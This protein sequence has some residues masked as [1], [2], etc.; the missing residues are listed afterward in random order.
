MSRI[1]RTFASEADV[2]QF[3][4]D[5]KAALGMPVVGR[6]A[7]TG[8]P[9]P[10]K[11]QTTDWVQVGPATDPEGN[12]IDNLTVTVVRTDHA[13]WRDGLVRA[14]LLTADEIAAL[15]NEYPAWVTGTEYAAGDLRAHAGTLWK[16]VQGHTSQS[17]WQPG[18]VPA[19]WTHAAPA[20][21]IAEWVQ[22]TGAHD[23]YNTG[24]RV[25]FNGQVYESLSNANVWSPTAYP[26]GWKL[27]QP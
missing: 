4:E 6:N 17:D 10:D 9:A 15:A 18:T 26:Q 19:L 24:D 1:T 3:N 12:P 23:A 22:P 5:A 21:V 20:G 27:I 13:A 8:Q 25:T 2:L 7:R 14:D 11:Q 16:C